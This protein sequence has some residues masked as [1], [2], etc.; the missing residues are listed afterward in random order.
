MMR[1]VGYLLAILIYLPLCVFGVVIDDYFMYM[2]ETNTTINISTPSTVDMVA[3]NG[4]YANFTNLYVNMIIKNNSDIIY[5]QTNETINYS[6][7]DGG[8][9][10]FF[11]P[12]DPHST[13]NETEPSLSTGGGGGYQI[14]TQNFDLVI[15]KVTIEDY[16]PEYSDFYAVIINSSE[17]D[18]FTFIAP[19]MCRI[20][21]ESVFG[22]GILVNKISCLKQDSTELY[23]LDI[24]SS[25]WDESVIVEVM[26]QKDNK[27]FIALNSVWNILGEGKPIS[28]YGLYVSGY[29]FTSIIFLAIGII[30][31]FWKK[32]KRAGAAP[33]S[34]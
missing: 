6:F 22:A 25:T 29:I 18:N 26:P 32:K 31:V 33:S 30:V 2:P 7:H 13:E 9:W 16:E 3:Y 10:T 20:E 24:E 12:G 15:E 17:E 8:F 23:Y 1:K 4:S 19:P 21:K 5:N 14:K 11:L 34:N 27:F 28:I